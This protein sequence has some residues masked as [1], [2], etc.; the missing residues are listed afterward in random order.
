MLDFIATSGRTATLI[1]LF[2][3]YEFGEFLTLELQCLCHFGEP[4]DPEM[5]NDVRPF[6]LTF[7][8]SASL[9]ST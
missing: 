4:L 3:L 5:V 6:T 9:G 8:R 7:L 2:R 1:I